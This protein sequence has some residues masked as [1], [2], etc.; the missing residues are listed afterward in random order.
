MAQVHASLSTARVLTMSFE[1]GV[2]V[3][4]VTNTL[5][6]EPDTISFSPPMC[7]L[8]R[9]DEKPLP[10]KRAHQ[11]VVVAGLFTSRTYPRHSQFLSSQVP[12]YSRLR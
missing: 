8:L 3:T 1:E 7:T 12:H 6:H 2:S 5:V 4:D 10:S 11:L 9:T